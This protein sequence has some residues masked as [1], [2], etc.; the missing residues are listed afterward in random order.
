MATLTIELPPR[1]Q[2]TRFN[3]RRWAE[4]QADAELAKIEG[5]I[6]T[7]RHGQIIMSPPPAPAHGNFQATIARLLQTLIPGGSVFTECPISTADG[8]RAADVAWAS[9]ERLRELGNR[10]CFPTAPEICVEVLSPS[11]TRAQVAE[12]MALYFD[13]GAQEVWLCESSGMM[14]FRVAGANRPMK[15]SRLCPS[16]PKKI[17]RQ[18]G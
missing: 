1:Q 5:R 11:N 3:L 17:Q 15:T 13:A 6:E 10:A 14:R 8:V 2:Q 9:A 7:D 18:H 12:K 16:F 4:L